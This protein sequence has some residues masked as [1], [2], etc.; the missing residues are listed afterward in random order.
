MSSL[1]PPRVV[2]R[3]PEGPPLSPGRSDTV[4][5][6]DGT[7][8]GIRL[9]HPDDAPRLKAL[10]SRLSGDSLYFRFLEIR[11]G[12]SDEEVKH[13]ADVDYQTRPALVATRRQA[14]REEII[15]VARY[16]TIETAEPGLAELSIVV[17]DCYQSRGLGTRLLKR[18]AAYAR[19]HGVHTFLAVVHP[20]NVRMVRLV[21]R[22]GLPTQSKT[23]FG[24]REIR[25][26]LEVNADH[27]DAADPEQ[28]GGS[29]IARE[30][31][32]AVK[33]V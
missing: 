19:A 4:T 8:V 14:D 29:F 17:E 22:S 28:H 30:T 26:G 16:A 11:K 24:A 31:A 6:R 27:R 32:V 20:D 12:L 7:A 21:Q 2:E 9:L 1:A 33:M 18:L 13:L 15:A 3:G 25:M 10:Y 23:E 5:L